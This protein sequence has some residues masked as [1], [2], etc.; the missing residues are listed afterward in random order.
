MTIALPG[1]HLLFL[2]VCSPLRLVSS[3]PSRSP[4]NAEPTPWSHS[5]TDNPSFILFFSEGKGAVRG[6]H[7]ILILSPSSSIIYPFAFTSCISSPSITSLHLYPLPLPSPSLRNILHRISPHTMTPFES[8]AEHVAPCESIPEPTPQATPNL[9]PPLTLDQLE[10]LSKPKVIIAGAGLAGLTLG[11]LLK[12]ANIPFQ[13]FEKSSEFKPLGKT[14]FFF[15]FFLDRLILLE[16][17]KPSHFQEQKV[18]QRSIS[19]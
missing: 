18:Y 13:I 10:A 15:F 9:G 17:K 4:L 2:M 3:L 12:K 6:K 8:T 7:R 11:I 19:L 1:E 5:M 14:F 16:L